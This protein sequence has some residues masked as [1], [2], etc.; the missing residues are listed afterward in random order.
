MTVG[1]VGRLTPLGT[2]VTDVTADGHVTAT[3]N[4]SEGVTLRHRVT[5]D[6]TSVTLDAWAARRPPRVGDEHV[7]SAGAHEVVGIDVDA[8]GRTWLRLDNGGKVEWE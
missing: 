8:D 6:G 5:S 7:T 3:V 2:V 1:K 4:A